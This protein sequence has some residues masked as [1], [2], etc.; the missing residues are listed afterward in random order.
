MLGRERLK[1]I[2][3]RLCGSLTVVLGLWTLVWLP[4]VLGESTAA[5]PGEHTLGAAD[6]P[7]EIIEYASLTCPHCAEFHLEILPELKERYIA[8]GKV[9]LT[10]RD[11][12]LDQRALAA[13]V[14]AECAGPDR[15]FGLLDVLFQ[16]QETWAA[17]GDLSGLKQ[18]GRLA[19]MSDQQMDQCFADEELQNRILQSRLDAQNEFDVTSTPTF[20]IDGKVYAGSRDLDGFAEIID[21]LLG[22]S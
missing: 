17:A 5:E 21:P 4:L 20:V 22:D 19:G 3:L 1:Q 11:F 12:P 18:L 7:V 13:S 9:K 8:P 10:Y 6:A 16:T 14:L 15:Y 2:L